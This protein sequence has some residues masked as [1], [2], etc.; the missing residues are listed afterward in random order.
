MSLQ[1]H[2]AYED[3]RTCTESIEFYG[4]P[5]QSKEVSPPHVNSLQVLRRLPSSKYHGD[6]C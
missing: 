2:T 5:E 4:V 1:K 6:P 3:T